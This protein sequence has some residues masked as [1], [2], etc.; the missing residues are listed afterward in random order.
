MA[1]G[2]AP[3]RCIFCEI[4]QRKSPSHIFYEDDTA[5]AFLDIFPFTRGHALVVPKHHV[6][7]LTD[8]PRAQYTGFL[9]GLSEVCRRI[10]RLST[11][12]NV[13]LN[14]GALAGQIVFH[15][16]FHIIPRYDEQNPFRSHP[17]E[18]LED[19]DAR[20]LVAQLSAP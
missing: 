9:G 7:R 3:Q 17:R 18:R 14:Q 6:D 15:L 12:Y 19:A 4:V 20:A 11:H 8:L 13:A 16:H 5:L 2:G 1:A 10:E